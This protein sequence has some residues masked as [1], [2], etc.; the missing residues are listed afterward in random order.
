MAQKL[1]K[2]PAKFKRD[3]LRA[4]L[5]PAAAAA[6]SESLPEVSLKML[7]F[8]AD[9]LGSF[10]AALPPPFTASAGFC[11]CLLDL[12]GGGAGADGPA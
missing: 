12:G 3:G 6:A 5:R 7:L 10:L 4:F 8:L 9:I 11:C 2:K 1:F